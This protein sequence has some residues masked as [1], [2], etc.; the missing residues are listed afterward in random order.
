MGVGTI[1]QALLAVVKAKHAA[2]R[3]FGLSSK[4]LIVDE[5][6]EMG[7]P[8]LGELLAK[9]LE[10]HAAQGGSAILL[11][12]TIPLNLRAMLVPAPYGTSL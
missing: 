7:D 3:L 9:L 5:V 8:Y 11:S 6:H 10:V 4:I 12:A 1:D 2:L